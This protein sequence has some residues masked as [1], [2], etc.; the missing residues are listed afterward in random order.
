MNGGSGFDAFRGLFAG[1]MI[2]HAGMAFVAGLI[3]LW[4]A[5][6]LFSSFV[7]YRIARKMYPGGFWVY[8][9]PI[10]RVFLL[11]H[12]AGVSPWVTAGIYAPLGMV[13]VS[14]VLDWFH[15]AFWGLTFL[16][17][18]LRFGC[19]VVLWGRVAQRF[20]LNF[21]LWGLL[22]ALMP[23]LFVCQTLLALEPSIRGD[24]ER[25][26]ELLPARAPIGGIEARRGGS[27]LCLRGPFSGQG[28]PVPEE[29]LRMGREPKGNDLVLPLAGISR[30]HARLVPCKGG[31]GLEDLQS[32]N[33]TYLQRD[34]QWH[35]VTGLVFLW[36]GARFRLGGG[37]V[38]FELRG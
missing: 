12:R 31:W 30:F 37:E 33:G 7:L 34:G 38:E 36:V 27:L 16:A 35:P 19:R 17:F 11:G 28:M 1:W 22:V 25:R 32:T 6:Y 26:G 18:A 3:V 9:V 8:L 14:R 21:W 29:G 15:P 13:L 24:E 20:G 23:D 4:I 5:Y 10:V 2:G